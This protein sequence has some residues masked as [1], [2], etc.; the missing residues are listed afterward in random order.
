[1]ADD[2]AFRVT[3]LRELARAFKK[4]GDVDGPKAI[5]QA[6]LAA[7]RSIA[8]AARPLLPVVTGRLQASLRP[9]AT[10]RASRVVLGNARVPYAMAVH[11]GTG[12]R[13]GLRGPHNIKRRAVVWEARNRFAAEVRRQYERELGVVVGRI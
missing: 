6:N 3:G 4:A 9:L 8:D 5:R 10:Q 11:W 2:V 7:A 12:P 1:M 13:P